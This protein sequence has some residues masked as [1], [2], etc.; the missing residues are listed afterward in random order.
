MLSYGLFVREGKG[1]G[2]GRGKAERN[3]LSHVSWD[4]ALPR[5]VEFKKLCE[6]TKKVNNEVSQ[7]VVTA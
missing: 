7:K 6:T 3:L 4:S 1:K 2:K 5:A